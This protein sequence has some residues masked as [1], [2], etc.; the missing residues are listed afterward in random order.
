[1]DKSTK[2]LIKQKII[3]SYTKSEKERCSDSCFK[4]TDLISQSGSK[5][6]ENNKNKKVKKTKNKT[7]TKTEF[8][9]NDYEET[10]EEMDGEIDEKINEQMD[11]GSDEGGEQDDDKDIDFADARKY[12]K[13]GQKFITPPNGDGSRAFYESLLEE[14]SNSI[15]AIK[16]CI[17]H[18]V[19]SGTKHH[20]ALYKYYVLKKNNAF[21]NIIGGIKNEFISLLEDFNNNQKK[22]VH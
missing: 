6:Y 13:E 22:M 4:D 16:Y 11:E 1:M 3:K 12:F 17:E 15:I 21:R 19:L 10:D 14:N 18:G 7:F 9:E 20:E 8:E 2:K 5:N